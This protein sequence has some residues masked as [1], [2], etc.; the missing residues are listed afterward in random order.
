[1]T[2]SRWLSCTDPMP[3]LDFL[4]GKASDRKLRL[5]A[6]A[7][8]RRIWDLITHEVS[9]KAVQTAEAY[10]DD[11]VSLKELNVTFRAADRVESNAVDILPGVEH[12]FAASAARLAAHP[13]IRGLADGTADAARMAAAF[14]KVKRKHEKIGI[15]FGE[16]YLREEPNEESD[17]CV[18]LR[19]IFGN[20]FRPIILD[21][22]WLTPTVK[23]LAQSIYDDRDF[24]QMPILADSLEK[25]GCDNQ[26]ILGHC[27]GMGPHVRGCWALDAVLGK[28]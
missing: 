20:P 6:V 27:R 16:H 1:M 9:R 19:D 8:S 2:E 12:A 23:A 11:R 18:L 14:S 3:M 21:P 24:D 5:F 28:E 13:E 26:E 22:S 17:Q 25:A 7:C 4:K 10:A 15:D